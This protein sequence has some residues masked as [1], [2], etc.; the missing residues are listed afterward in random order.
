MLFSQALEQHNTNK[1]ADEQEKRYED[2]S[3]RMP[4][5]FD[6]TYLALKQNK[7]TLANARYEIIQHIL[8]Q[9]DIVEEYVELY[10]L[11]V[12]EELLNQ[13]TVSWEQRR[14]MAHMEVMQHF[15]Q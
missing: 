14:R 15:S 4:L 9:A 10:G 12:Q 2:V 13:A 3:T 6:L 8:T 7:P 11:D 1:L 5:L